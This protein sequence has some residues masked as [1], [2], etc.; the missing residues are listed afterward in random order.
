MNTFS[1]NKN[2]R[3]VAFISTH[4]CP[5]MTPGMRSAGGMNVFLRRIAPLLSRQ[6]ILVDIFTRCHHV[7]GP[8]IFQF[9]QNSH[10]FHLPAGNPQIS[11]DEITKHLDEFTGNLLD[12]ISDNELSY[13]LV[14]SHYWLSASAGQSLA[15]YLGV[16]HLFTF[17]T[18]AEI[19]ERSG[20]HK[21]GSYRKQ[22]E[23]NIAVTADGI[24][25]FTEEESH[26]M[27]R[28][29]GTEVNKT[30]AVQLGVD[31]KLFHPGSQSDSR[32]RL[33]LSPDS[34]IILFV[35]RIEYFKGPELLLS[36]VAQMQNL[37]DVKILFVGG[38]VGDSSLIWLK[39][40]A[41]KLGVYEKIIW[42]PAVPQATL[43]DYYIASDLC[44]I[45]S[46]NE[47]FGLVALEAMACRTPVVSFDIGGLKSIVVNEVTG[48]RV[49]PGDIIE[50]GNKFQKI[51][52]DN[53][54]AK[55]LG[56]HSFEHSKYFSWEH[57]AHEL[58]KIYR[59]YVTSESSYAALQPNEKLA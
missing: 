36:S 34:K 39:G 33:G 15:N 30:N 44:A 50:M 14:H 32:L 8:E 12:F 53:N 26:A 18:S 43:P 5:L 9:E 55:N 22:S 42:H 28:I 40:I 41:S 4:G 51:L 2:C 27:H 37:D 54:L 46:L 52:F 59:S 11:K 16:P 19:K 20:G 7:G 17:H 58:S 21:E 56:D 6:G 31:S 13:D 38:D 25:T 47:T 48:Y 49:P 35:G 3:R 57:S 29:Y 24:I 23:A 45:P 10:I 1:I